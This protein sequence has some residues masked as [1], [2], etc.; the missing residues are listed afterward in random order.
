MPRERDSES[1]QYTESY[2]LDIFLSALRA[3]GGMAG[4]NDV[5]DQVGCSYEL[6]YQRLRELTENDQ[7]TRQKVGN[8][9]LWMLVQED[10][11]Q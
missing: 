9:N 7:L 5:A 10:E 6:A 2:P 4:T 3:E 1:G 11:Q 8:A